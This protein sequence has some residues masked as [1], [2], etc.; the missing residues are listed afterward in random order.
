MEDYFTFIASNDIRLKGTRIGIETILNDFL[1][2]GRT[3]DDI[4]Q[5]YPSL[6]LEQIYAT[7]LYYFHNQ[8]V[9]DQ[10]L[11]DWLEWSEQQRKYQAENPSPVVEKLKQLRQQLETENA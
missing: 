1:Y 9:I 4:A 2:H 6:T 10:Y 3:P 8:Q 5:A 7:L 11:V